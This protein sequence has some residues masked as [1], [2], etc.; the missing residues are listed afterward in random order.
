VP[1]TY[2]CSISTALKLAADT[3]QFLAM[4]HCCPA[5]NREVRGTWGQPW[6]ILH[7]ELQ[8]FRTGPG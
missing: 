2:G 7:R 4:G 6:D 5:A 3:D 8:V 1:P